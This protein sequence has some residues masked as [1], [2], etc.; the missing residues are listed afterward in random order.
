MRED[1]SYLK[2]RAKNVTAEVWEAQQRGWDVV[3][4]M[5]S[6]CLHEVGMQLLLKC[7]SEAEGWKNPSEHEEELWCL[8][9][10]VWLNYY[11]GVGWHQIGRQ[12]GSRAVFGNQK[13]ENYY[14][15]LRNVFP[16]DTR[17][18]VWQNL[19]GEG[20]RWSER[21]RSHHRIPFRDFA[22][23]GSAAMQKEVMATIE[24]K[25]PGNRNWKD[26]NTWGKWSLKFTRTRKPPV[27]V[28][29]E[30]GSGKGNKIPWMNI[31]MN[32]NETPHRYI[33]FT[34][35]VKIK[36]SKGQAVSWSS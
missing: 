7:M 33:L 35:H 4:S 32:E 22:S 15:F 31:N 36:L 10:C 24:T 1:A 8:R 23:E 34:D 26:N 3:C 28:M 13:T 20:G 11:L 16:T 29:K 5:R 2:L 21:Q 25:P 30:N 9:M 27:C 19:H 6:D 12:A 18:F 17:S 14:D